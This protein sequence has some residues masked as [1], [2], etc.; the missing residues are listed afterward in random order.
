[1]C[2]KCREGKIFISSVLASKPLG[3]YS[4]S[5]CQTKIVAVPRAQANCDSCD[6]SVV[7]YLENPEWNED[8]TFTGGNFVEER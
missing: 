2:P 3:S 5:G 4:I 6:F 1:M 7:G 8:G